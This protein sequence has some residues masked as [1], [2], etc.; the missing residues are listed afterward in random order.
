MLFSCLI[1]DYPVSNYNYVE[2]WQNK[3]LNWFYTTNLSTIQSLFKNTYLVVQQF[4][5]ADYAI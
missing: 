2:E 1:I 5:L 4:Y 3:A